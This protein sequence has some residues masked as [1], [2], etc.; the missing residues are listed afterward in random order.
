MMFDETTA[1]SLL[2]IDIEGNKVE[3]SG[4]G[5]NQADFV[6]HSAVHMRGTTSSAYCIPTPSPAAP[7]RARRTDYCR[8]IS[9]RSGDWG[10]RSPRFISPRNKQV[11]GSISSK[12]SQRTATPLSWGAYRLFGRFFF[13]HWGQLIARHPE[14]DRFVPAAAADIDLHRVGTQILQID[15]VPHRGRFHSFGFGDRNGLE[16][17][18]PQALGRLLF[19]VHVK[20][21]VMDP[22]EIGFLSRSEL[23][24]AGLAILENRK[25]NVTVAEPDTLFTGIPGSAIELGQPE[26]LLVKFCGLRGIIGHECDMSDASH[27]PSP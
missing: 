16:I 9:T 13:R 1:S 24:S 10:R 6:I 20:P 21:D 17:R 18:V 19:I 23:G 26:L 12:A 15:C 8:S 4:Y 22:P 3:L 5:V 25:I 2:K 14:A 11:V 7:S 27:P